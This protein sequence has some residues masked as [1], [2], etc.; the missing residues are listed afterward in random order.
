MMQPTGGANPSSM[1]VP[2][3]N[4]DVSHWAGA[5]GPFGSDPQRTPY[6]VPPILNRL[7]IEQYEKSIF[8]P[9]DAADLRVGFGLAIALNL[10][11]GAL[12]L[13]PPTKPLGYLIM[14]VPDYLVAIPLGV[15]ASNIY[16]GTEP[17]KPLWKSATGQ[18]EH[19]SQWG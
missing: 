6:D 7:V 1:G 12:W 5:I 10:V 18:P 13:F 9:D 8:Y 3:Q 15:A 14:A 2:I 17:I 4:T 19:W 16:Q 11:G